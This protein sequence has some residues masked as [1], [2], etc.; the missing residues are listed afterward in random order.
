M[1]DRTI[2]SAIFEDQ[3][4]SVFSLF[5]LND[6]VKYE[7]YQKKSVHMSGKL[8]LTINQQWQLERKLGSG[9]FGDVYCAAN[10]HTGAQVA[11]KL[12]DQE[13][14]CQQL[15]SEAKI[16][17]LMNEVQGIPKLLWYDQSRGYRM[18]LVSLSAGMERKVITDV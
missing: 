16:Y 5:S 3:I 14:S 12:E 8:R 2:E 9:A 17:R 10:I 11:V 7:T 13:T 6:R 18:D 1:T 4:F 15:A